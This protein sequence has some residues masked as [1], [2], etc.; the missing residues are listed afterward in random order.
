MLSWY[1]QVSKIH[2][3]KEG[4]IIHPTL[5][6]ILNALSVGILTFILMTW[7]RLMLM[8]TSDYFQYHSIR[9]IAKDFG[10]WEITFLSS[11]TRYQEAN[12]RFNDTLFCWFFPNDL[13]WYS[14]V[15]DEY[16][17]APA[18]QFLSKWVYHGE[19]PTTRMYCQL[20]SAPYVSLPFWVDTEP[21]LIET[22]QFT[23][24]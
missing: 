17:S 4:I 5:Y 8:Q 21:Q 19:K 23:V 9:P 22:S 3:M 16:N 10:T 1:S 11:L 6:W 18:W 24:N 13:F 14:Q 15:T 12:M 20:K 2:T 7:V